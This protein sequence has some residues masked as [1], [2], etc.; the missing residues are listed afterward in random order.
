LPPPAHRQFLAHPPRLIAIAD[1]PLWQD[2]LHRHAFAF[3]VGRLASAF[4]QHPGQ[5][6]LLLRLHGCPA[7]QWLDTLAELHWLRGFGL[8]LGISAPKLPTTELFGDLAAQL[9]AL[10]RAGVAWVQIGEGDAQA[11]ARALGEPRGRVALARSCHDL[12]GVGRALQAVAD[13]VSL[14][15]LLATPSK[16]GVQ[17]L[18]WALLQQT[19]AMYPG[20]I[21]ALGGIGAGEAAE[22]WRIGASVAVLRAWQDQPGELAAALQAAY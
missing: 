10:E 20:K 3:A 18:G 12:E 8:Q 7:E 17:A 13:W 2:P 6:G 5:I 22:V 16:P 21:A 15:P 4:R 14:S 1:A 19:A 11:W 9:S